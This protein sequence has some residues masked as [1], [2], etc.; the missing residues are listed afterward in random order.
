M[1]AGG[2]EPICG[3]RFTRLAGIVE[4]PH[5]TA[6]LA[7]DRGVLTG[8]G[9]EVPLCEVEV[10]HKSGSE[11]QTVVFAREIAAEFGLEPENKSKF[12]RALELR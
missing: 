8:G 5:G 11:A 4:L 7:L 12:R 2:V 9:R 3:A 10:E 6:E 1:T